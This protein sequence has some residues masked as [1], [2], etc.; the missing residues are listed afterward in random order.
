MDIQEDQVANLV[1]PSDIH[2]AVAADVV[3]NLI[4]NWRRS[5]LVIGVGAAV[6]VIIALRIPNRFSSE[7]QLMSPDPR[8][9][10]SDSVLTPTFG[11]GL[12]TSGLLGGQLSEKTPSSIAIGMMS[13]PRCLDDIINRLDL[14]SV[15]GVKLY[16]DARNALSAN[17]KFTED[18]KTGII[19][20]TVADRDKY[21]A[22]RI[23][24]A[25]IDDLNSLL[26]NLN[27][28]VAH[29]E[30]IFLEQRLKG[31][32]EDLDNSTKE[33]GE[34]SSQ[35]G[36]LDLARQGDQSMQAVGR[37]EGELYT[38]ESNLS[39]L[40]M[41]Y[42]VNNTRVRET[43]GKVNAL[44]SELQKMIGSSGRQIDENADS[45]GAPLPSVRQLPLLGVKYYDLYRQVN[46][47]EALYETLSKQYETAKVEEAKELPVVKVLTPPDVAEMKSFPPRKTIMLGGTLLT[48][49]GY[50]F[51]LVCSSYWAYTDE[52]SPLKNSLLTVVNSA[53]Q[54]WPSQT[55]VNDQR[56]PDHEP[57]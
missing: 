41:S 50:I 23:A 9:F 5:L 16:R 31:I 26:N 25:Y 43:Q 2:A 46:I 8:A 4:S 48:A 30:R 51:W 29:R 17:T 54:S 55:K 20:V 15:Y 42:T 36:A 57:Q 10:V 53:R 38:A 35:S 45:Q 1:E 40:K 22:Q 37:L 12:A 33:L 56:Q 19:K 28:S 47:E 49:C 21:R 7:A 39:A 6:F 13:S 14:R 18:R 24:Q 3:A 11:Q 27:V 32:K 52:L 44:R 34:F